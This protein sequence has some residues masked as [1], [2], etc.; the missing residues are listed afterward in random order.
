MTELSVLVNCPFKNVLFWNPHV[1]GFLTGSFQ[2]L[3]YSFRLRGQMVTRWPCLNNAESFELHTGLESWRPLGNVLKVWALWRS[4]LSGAFYIY[5]YIYIYIYSAIRPTRGE[6]CGSMCKCNS[7]G[8][9]PSHRAGL[10]PGTPAWEAGALP[11]RLKATASSVS[12]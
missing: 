5:I 11:R 10:K 7:P 3:P 6:A 1:S 12:R 8:S 9:A 2:D 4:Q